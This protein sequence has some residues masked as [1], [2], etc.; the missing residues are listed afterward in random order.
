[1]PNVMVMVQGSWHGQLRIRPGLSGL[2][3]YSAVVRSLGEGLVYVATVVDQGLLAQAFEWIETDEPLSEIPTRR[4]GLRLRARTDG[5]ER[6]KL[7]HLTALR[8]V[9]SH[10]EA[11]P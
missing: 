9:G 5:R 2:F 6:S 7:V 8:A 1:M 4:N 11:Y 10:R 3:C